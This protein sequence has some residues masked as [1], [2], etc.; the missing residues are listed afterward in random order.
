M[1]G[2]DIVNIERIK[3]I[4]DSENSYT[5]C[6]MI[7]SDEELKQC[8]RERRATFVQSVAEGFS[9]KEAVIKASEGDLKLSDIRKIVLKIDE[10]E[11]IHVEIIEKGE[12]SKTYKTSLCHNGKYTI[13]V[14]ILDKN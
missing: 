4:L 5:F 12:S 14:A 10:K 9:I 8:R 7:F 13:A 2:I 1:I 11:A 3:K 6:K